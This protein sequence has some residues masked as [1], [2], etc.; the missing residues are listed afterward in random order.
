MRRGLGKVAQATSLVRE[1]LEVSPQDP[2]LWCSLGDLTLDDAC[3][4]KAWEVSAHRHARA[5]RSLA[6]RHR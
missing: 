5:Q 6:N 1:R 3:Y 4:T 2:R